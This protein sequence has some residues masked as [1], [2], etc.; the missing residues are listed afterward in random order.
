LYFLPDLPATV[1]KDSSKWIKMLRHFINQEN[2]ARLK[3]RVPRTALQWQEIMRIV[4][5]HCW[6]AIDHDQIYIHA[7]RSPTDYGTDSEDDW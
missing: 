7:S 4:K 2:T 3:D 1:D 6:D 5:V